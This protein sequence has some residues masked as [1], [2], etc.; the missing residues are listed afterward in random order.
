MNP[1]T[2]IDRKPRIGTD[3]RMSSTGIRIFSACRLLAAS[4]RIGEAEDERGDERRAHAQHRAQRV[5]RQPPR[6]E[7][8]RQR[9]ADLV[10]RAHRHAAPGDERESAQHQRQRDQVPVRSGAAATARR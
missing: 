7:A 4:A 2:V 9:L 3:C 1:V 10:V 6:V 5:F 8:D